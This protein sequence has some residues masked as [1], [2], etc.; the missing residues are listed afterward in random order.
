L[1]AYGGVYLAFVPPVQLPIDGQ[2]QLFSSALQQFAELEFWFAVSSV[3][4]SSTHLKSLP[5]IYV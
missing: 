3:Q 2:G 5:L 1:T 4:V